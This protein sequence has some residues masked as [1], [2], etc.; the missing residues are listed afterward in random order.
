MPDI[1]HDDSLTPAEAFK[2]IEE[3]KNEMDPEDK[4]TNDQDEP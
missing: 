4:N 3:L 2:K 1:N